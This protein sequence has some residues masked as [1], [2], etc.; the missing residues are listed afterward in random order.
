MNQTKE[1]QASNLAQEQ[2]WPEMI[3][4]H[5]NRTIGACTIQI[6][7]WFSWKQTMVRDS[8]KNANEHKTSFSDFLQTSQPNYM[9]QTSLD[10][11]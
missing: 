4:Q 9:R 2:I 8:S 1:I 7:A 6:Q 5:I 3:E 11:A 10:S